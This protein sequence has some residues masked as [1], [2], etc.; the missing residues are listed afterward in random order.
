MEKLAEEIHECSDNV[1]NFQ[2]AIDDAG[3]ALRGESGVGDEDD[4]LQLELDALM[5]IEACRPRA[6]VL[7]PELT[8]SSTRHTIGTMDDL[9]I[10]SPEGLRARLPQSCSPTAESEN[11]RMQVSVAD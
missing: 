3:K 8:I 6:P 11:E 10:F 5:G 4:D 7:M 1:K 2:E 9:D